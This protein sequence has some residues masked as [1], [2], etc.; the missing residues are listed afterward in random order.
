[1]K[2][3]SFYILFQNFRKQID[4]KIF[5]TKFLD[6]DVLSFMAPESSDQ[7][8]RAEKKSFFIY[9]KKSFFKSDPLP[10]KS[11]EIYMTTF[12]VQLTELLHVKKFPST[13]HQ[14]N[15]FCRF[16]GKRIKFELY[17]LHI[18]LDI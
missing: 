15:I 14:I 4:E 10:T 1:M 16:N 5:A 9:T 3:I 11:T 13:F 7:K 12:S 2:M 6:G 8:L 18:L 17:V